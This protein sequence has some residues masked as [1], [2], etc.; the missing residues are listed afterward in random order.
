[1][2]VRLLDDG[3]AVDSIW[4]PLIAAR[5][6]G[7]IGVEPSDLTV[8]T[9]RPSGAAADELPPDWRIVA[10]AYPGADPIDAVGGYLAER[11][12]RP[13]TETILV[14]WDQGPRRNL[15]VGESWNLGWTGEA[16]FII[17]FDIEPYLTLPRDQAARLPDVRVALSL[18]AD[19]LLPVLPDPTPLPRP[20]YAPSDET[21][22]TAEPDPPLEAMMPSSAGAIPLTVTSFSQLREQDLNGFAGGLHFLLRS[23]FDRPARDHSLAVAAAEGSTFSVWAHRIDGVSGEQL[24]GAVLGEMFAGQLGGGRSSFRG[25][26]VDGRRYVIDSGRA[27]YAQGDI[28]YWLL[29]LDVGGC[30]DE[31]DTGPRPPLEE[32]VREAIA[33]IPEG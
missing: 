10:I 33:D 1:M 14:P 19:A 13:G 5:M 24:L 28:L 29:Y 27:F 6:A 9:A 11:M 16:L 7:Q 32:M 3:E 23:Q 30:F 8:A 18:T 25:E 17:D 2:D 21:E 31:C 4:D 15:L 22:P 26:E 12:L 20:S